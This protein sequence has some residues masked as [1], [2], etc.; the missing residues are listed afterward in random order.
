MALNVAMTLHTSQLT[1][2][3]PAS[4]RSV[5]GPALRSLD[6]FLDDAL[7]VARQEAEDTYDLVQWIAGQTWCDGRVVMLGASY[8]AISQYA[9]AALQPPALR[10]ICCKPSFHSA[11][12]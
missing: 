6:R 1:A 11:R 3:T 2:T 9:V 5:Y 10:A 8:L 7:T 4:R 12:A